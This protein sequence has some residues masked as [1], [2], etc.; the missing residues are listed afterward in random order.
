M[1]DRSEPAV[2][3][4]LLRALSSPST[5][6]GHP[7]VSVRETHASVVFVAGEHAYKIKKPVTFGFL[8]YGTLERRRDACREEVRVNQALAPGIYLGVLAIAPEDDG[9][10]LAAEDTPGAV[11]YAVDMLSFRE[12]DTMRARIGAGALTREQVRDVARVLAGFHRT[13]EVAAEWGPDRLLAVWQRNIREMVL[14]APP[15]DWHPEVAAAFADAFVAGHGEELRARADA[16]LARDGHGDLRCEHILL[17]PSIRVVDRIEFDAGLRRTDVASD[18]AFLAM[19]LEA[20]GQRWAA[21]ELVRAYESAGVR[22]GSH[23][24]QAFYAAHRA[25]VRAKVA[26]ISAA[27]REGAESSRERRLAQRLWQLGERLC[28]R[29]R[30]PSLLVVCGP[31]ASGKSTLARELSAPSGMPVLSSDEVRKR[32]AGVPASRRASQE[33]YSEGF[34]H[35]TYRQ[36]ALEGIHA[37]QR[38][39]GAIVDATCRVPADRQLLLDGLAASGAQPLLVYCDV[40]LEAALERAARR[41][42]DPERVSDATPDIVRAHYAEFEDLREQPG[43]ALLRVDALG[44]LDAQVADVALALDRMQA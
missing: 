9:F 7:P 12:Q 28:W 2:D 33:H 31:A 32:M 20:S 16:G 40:P 4:V 29:A 17:E 14:A 25:F 38:G 24:L 10:R 21:R 37:L 35:A 30:A 39:P 1:P 11:E 19:D 36:L 8:D 13:A 44:A 42:S 43:A 41:L 22:A 3:P 27:E 6:P 23:E 26:L 34:S 5:Y 15:G 18:L